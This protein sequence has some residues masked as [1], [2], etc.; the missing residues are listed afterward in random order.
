MVTNAAN[1]AKDYE[2]LL[3]HREGEVKVKDVSRDYAQLAVQG[4][5]AEQILNS[6]TDSDLGG[7][8]FFRFADDI[9]IDGVE[10]L[11]SRTGYTGEDGFEIYSA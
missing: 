7:I 9:L 10:A 8:K 5:D 6:L 1:T 4:P 3:T 11:I 2:W